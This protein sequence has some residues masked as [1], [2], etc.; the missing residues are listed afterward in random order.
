M[1]L[2]KVISQFAI[3]ESARA[4]QLRIEGIEGFGWREFMEKVKAEV[5]MIMRENRQMKVKI[6]SCGMITENEDGSVQLQD[7][8]FHTEVIE[9]LRATDGSQA[10]D[11]FVQTFDER[12]QKPN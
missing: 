3:H 2:L 4:R 11:R 9:I 5:L 1:N 8:F 10:F 7:A 12:S 6:L